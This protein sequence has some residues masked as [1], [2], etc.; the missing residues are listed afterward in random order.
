M[1]LAGRMAA[2]VSYRIGLRSSSE[3]HETKSFVTRHDPMRCQHAIVLQSL[4]D[5]AE[6]QSDVRVS[7]ACA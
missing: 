6:Y 5:A 7:G 4:R 1:I 3:C 2:A